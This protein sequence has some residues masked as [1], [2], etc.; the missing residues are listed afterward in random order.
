MMPNFL[1]CD[2]WQDGSH[3]AFETVWH[4]TRDASVL[5]QRTPRCSPVPNRAK[6]LVDGIRLF[7]RSFQHFVANE[8]MGTNHQLPIAMTSSF[9]TANHLQ[10]CLLTVPLR[11]TP[12]SCLV[13]SLLC[14][15]ANCHREGVPATLLLH[16]CPPLDRLLACSSR[17]SDSFF[18]VQD[19]LSEDCSCESTCSSVSCNWCMQSCIDW[20]RKFLAVAFVPSSLPC[21]VVHSWET[22]DAWK[23]GGFLLEA[24]IASSFLPLVLEAFQWVRVCW[25]S[26]GHGS[27]LFCLHRCCLWTPAPDQWQW[28][29]S[30]WP[31]NECAM[32]MVF[33][34]LLFWQWLPWSGGLYSP[35]GFPMC[36]KCSNG[37]LWLDW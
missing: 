23:V 11:C 15:M 34:I 37:F 22:L 33:Q 1:V 25:L 30:Q 31:W 8:Q 29:W 35:R 10:L 12:S 14:L 20:S 6:H 26:C 19:F 4:A 21:T 28:F 27:N 3:S 5:G 9:A 18:P 17:H 7:R 2:L 36:H 16:L 32:C 24:D 13:C